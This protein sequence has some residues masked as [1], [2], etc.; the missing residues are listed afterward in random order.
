MVAWEGSAT[1]VLVRNWYK[2]M[3]QF[4]SET[5]ED[6]TILSL[7]LIPSVN[8]INTISVKPKFIKY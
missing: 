7:Q 6:V 2:E 3:L 1:F 8:T 4:T 5:C